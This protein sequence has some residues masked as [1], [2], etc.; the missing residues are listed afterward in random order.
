MGR[1]KLYITPKEI[2]L[3]NT[4]KSLK[5]YYKNRTTI[6]KKR[7]KLYYERKDISKKLS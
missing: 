4:K 5:Y 1:K 3:A 2:K 6:N 7:M